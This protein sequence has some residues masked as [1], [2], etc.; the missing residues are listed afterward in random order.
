MVHLISHLLVN[1]YIVLRSNFFRDVCFK[2]PKC[3][4]N[5]KIST[6]FFF[7]FCYYLWRLTFELGI[8]HMIFFL[9]ALVK[10]N[11][12]LTIFM[13]FLYLSLVTF[14]LFYFNNKIVQESF[15]TYFDCAFLGLGF[16][17][18]LPILYFKYKVTLRDFYQINKFPFCF[19]ASFMCYLLLSSNVATAQTYLSSIPNGLDYFRIFVATFCLLLE[20]VLNFLFSKLVFLYNSKNMLIRNRFIL[21][22]FAQG[23]FGFTNSLQV[24][25]IVSSSL[26]DWGL[27]YQFA[28]SV[29]G[30]INLMSNNRL[31]KR[32]YNF[33]MNS[34]CASLKKIVTKS[35]SN[36]PDS[37]RQLDDETLTI[38]ISQK[39]VCYFVIIPRILFLFTYRSFCSPLADLISKK[40][41]AELSEKIEINI[42]PIILF[43]VVEIAIIL[44]FFLQINQK[45]KHRLLKALFEERFMFVKVSYY[46][47]FQAI[48][49]SWLR[50]FLIAQN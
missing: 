48:Y 11:V 38:F 13:L 3:P 47:S 27:Y 20:F 45:K 30:N 32:M 39:I 37:S 43:F 41:V 50:F 14:W 36:L 25:I 46:M 31:M 1:L 28:L 19:V 10:K 49:E 24:G 15:I 35:A 42:L 23:L 29:Y 26:S 34:F 40:C 7:L 21:K 18:F 8:F 12:K 4:L 5:C 22:M 2:N 6:K 44:G 9:N 33:L 16:L 17:I